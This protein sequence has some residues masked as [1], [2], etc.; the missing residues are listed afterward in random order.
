MSFWGEIAAVRKGYLM[1]PKNRFLGQRIMP[2][3]RRR[4]ASL[5]RF[6]KYREIPEYPGFIR[7]LERRV[8]PCARAELN[9]PQLPP[10]CMEVS[11]HLLHA[12]TSFVRVK[13]ALMISTHEPGRWGLFSLIQ[14]KNECCHKE[15]TTETCTYPYPRIILVKRLIVIPLLPFT[16]GF[17]LFFPDSAASFW[18][19]RPWFQLHW[20]QRHSRRPQQ[21]QRWQWPRQ[22]LCRHRQL[23][24]QFIFSW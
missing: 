7:E 20:W 14:Q 15:E 13:N 16:G 8:W 6:P 18:F 2:N 9:K 12:L 1:M 23:A 10:S 24:S 21:H 5:F 19:W 3:N 4:V 11:T 17:F 22:L